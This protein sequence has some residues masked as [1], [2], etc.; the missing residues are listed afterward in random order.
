MQ[1]QHALVT[2]KSDKLKLLFYELDSKHRFAP[3][4]SHLPFKGN[5][6]PAKTSR[7]LSNPE[8]FL[9]L[10]IFAAVYRIKDLLI[11]S[12]LN[13][14]ILCASEWL[15]PVENSN[16]HKAPRVLPWVVSHLAFVDQPKN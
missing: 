7:E 6:T 12:F 4:Y 1:L 2:L 9:Q 8:K 13:D 5:K 3:A 16:G 14:C 15:V 10:A 11:G